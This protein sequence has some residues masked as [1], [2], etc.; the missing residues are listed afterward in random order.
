MTISP[1]RL[2]R[3]LAIVCAVGSTAACASVTRGVHQTWSVETTPSGAQVM[4]SNGF[5]CDQT[6]CNFHMERKAEF[7]V[8]ISKDGY[9]TWTGHV[10]HGVSLG[11]GAS[12]AGSM[13]L[14]GVAGAGID[15]TSGAIMDLK[16]N[17][18]KVTLEKAEATAAAAPAATPGAQ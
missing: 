4:T 1:M 3:A 12:M 9:K 14:G 5:A 15:A 13:L 6:P 2:L 10:T 11:G 8:T 17:P 7:E 16:P 18:L